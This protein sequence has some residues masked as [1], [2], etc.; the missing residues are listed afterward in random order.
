MVSINPPLN[1]T[2][3]EWIDQLYRDRLRSLLSIDDIIHDVI[4]YLIKYDVLNNTYILYTSDH[5]YHLG[6]WRIACSKQQM[7]E[8]DIRV[9]MFMR[10]P[11][12]N[13]NAKTR[14]MV[15][16]IDILPTF[17]DLAGIVLP[18]A[19]IIDGKSWVGSIIDEFEFEY[20][21]T[22]N[23]YHEHDNN[24]S[25]NTS[26][27]EKTL[28][29][30]GN[31]NVQKNLKEMRKILRQNSNTSDFRSV[32]LSQFRGGDEDFSHCAVWWIGNST[33]GTSIENRIQQSNHQSI[34]WTQN[35]QLFNQILSKDDRFSISNNYTNSSITFDELN[36]MGVDLFD[37]IN[38]KT[39]I[40]TPFGFPGVVLKPPA[41]NAFGQI[42]HVNSKE[43]NTWRMIRILNS[44]HN[45]AYGEFIN[46]SWT[47]DDKE[48][49][50]F[51]ELYDLENDFYQTRNLYFD[52]KNDTSKQGLLNQLHSML[53]NLGACSGFTCLQ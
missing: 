11:N 9:P 14:S 12:I 50:T 39:D 4:E 5:G 19:S 15:G 10:G 16:N 8:T 13:W 29:A 46:H 27:R 6:Q 22:K 47:D 33:N 37:N 52:Y 26:N 49:P 40:G 20:E 51:I 25:I 21:N 42:W 43:T 34:E 7:Y 41:A 44:T 38:I 36:T 35:R 17:V 2:A 48:N 53:M 45:W 1:E 18:N 28:L 32:F 31:K 24:G 3:I 30:N 23:K